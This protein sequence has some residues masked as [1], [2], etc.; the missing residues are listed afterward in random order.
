MKLKYLFSAIIASVLLLVGCE[1]EPIGTFEDIKLSSTNVS[2]PAE[3]GEVSVTLT[4]TIDWAFVTTDFEWLTL[5][6][7]TSGGAGEYV[8]KFS[9]EAVSG[10]RDLTLE[11]KAGSH[12]QY[13]T[14]RQGTKAVENATCADVIAGVDGKVYRVTG[15]CTKIAN[16]LYGNWYLNDGTGEVYVYGTLD[17]DGATKNFSSWKMEAGD[18]VTVEGPRKDYNGTIELVD[19]TVLNIEKSLLKIEEKP[20]AIAKEGGEYLL[21]LS[22]KGSGVQPSV[23]AVDEDG[24][25]VDYREWISV[26]AV[27]TKFGEATKLE[28][29]PADT[30]FVTIRIQPNDG[31][32]RDGRID[33]A[34]GTDEASSTVPFEFTQEGAI[35][36]V[37][38]ADAIASGELCSVLGKVI[39]THSK[40]VLITDGRDVL[41]GYLGAA[42]EVAVNDVVKM[43]G[44]VTKY[45]GGRSMNKPVVAKAEGTVGTYRTP[46]PVVLDAEKFAAYTSA[47]ADFATPYVM[48][49]GVAETDD[50]NNLIVKLV[51][52]ETTYSVKS[53]YGNDSFA[54]WAG[55]EVKAYGYAYNAYADSKQVNLV[56][57]TVLDADA[58]EPTGP[59]ISTI[60][61]VLALGQEDEIPEG[62]TVE[63]VVISNAALSNLTSKKGMYLQDDSGAVQLRF[64][65]DHTFAFGDKLQLDLSGVKV[66]AYNQAVQLSVDNTKA[67]FISAGNTVTPKTVT[68]ADF[69][70]NKYEGQYV[71]LEGV[72]VV[73]ADLA[74]TWGDAKQSSHVSINMED[75]E[76]N[77]FVVFSSKYST[78][79]GTT[80][81][82]GSGTI[83]GISAKS[84]ATI[85]L[86][87][88]QE[89][90]FA[91]LTGA[92]F[93]QEGGE[94]PTEKAARNLAFSSATATA[95]LGE[96]FTA[97]TLSGE[98]AGVVYTSSN[99]AVA[100][101]DAATGVVTLV[102]AGE[103]TITATA[104]ETETLQAGTASYTLTVSEAAVELPAGISA[105][106]ALATAAGAS[107]NVTLNDAVVT[108]VSGSNA[109]VQDT[110]AGILIYNSGHG[111]MA[112][113]KL[114][115]EVSGTVKLFNNLREITDI[116]ISQA[117]KTSGAAIPVTELTL[118]EL[119][120]EGAYDRYENMRISIKNV[121]M[122]AQKEISQ[123]GQK[124]AL[125]FRSNSL[126]GYEMYNL[127]DFVGYPGKYNNDIQLNVYEDATVLGATMTT[128]SGFGNVELTVGDTKANKAVA[129]SGATVSYSSAAENIATVD[130]EGN[131]TGVAEGETTITVSVEA[132]NGYP[133][134]TATCTVN[135]LP[136]GAVVEKAWTLVTDASTLAVGDK[137]VIAAKGSNVAISTE[138]KSN[139]RGQVAITK[140]GN[141]MTFT[142]A[143]Q[144][145]TL[146]AGTKT[147]TFAFNVGPS[148][149]L[150]AASSSSNHLKTGSKNDNAS[151]TIEITSA[152][153]ATI[154][155]QGTNTRN[156][157]R[158]NSQSSLFACYG[159]GQEDVAIYKYQ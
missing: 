85:Q 154:K 149:Y 69:L 18:I 142:T 119:N 131:V 114:S 53:Y 57:V 112:G 155:A 147:G 15:V 73:E 42:P 27:E 91:G 104:A 130:A 28:P 134:A 29:N 75:A 4:T 86:I 13:I 109:Y 148:Q 117:E 87:F 110:E 77:T 143:V 48:I 3:G 105:I 124:Y 59:E 151:W 128:F 135:V 11:I 64:T 8:L 19:V 150:Y 80:V 65:D 90:D 159:S 108:Y 153:V 141:T 158:H 93:G 102:A 82:Q 76:G 26:V 138:Q 79:G 14:I 137:I 56:A 1:Q 139:N 136:A 89:S 129:S 126:K 88:A 133:A 2:I 49:T 120:A 156:W 36:E 94:E 122:T 23:P 83:K 20:E 40:G 118:A 81:A 25:S 31:A 47:D 7:P 33:F 35:E 34:S 145:I 62:T 6:G 38:I 39:F 157:L 60:A 95:T 32:T 22:Y 44:T 9:A 67:V 45:N 66:G 127:I 55:K 111:L 123:N 144:E 54:D 98:A 68:M 46:A 100:T 132:Y 97:P 106:K 113:D 103:T 78:F 101:V 92:R 61:S 63:G 21:K 10:G 140:S 107:F 125:Y 52:G 96:A 24:N 74:K 72:Q 51:D 116:N 5:D 70:A 41:Y 30:A 71:A 99:T 37:T 84:N 121:E 146:E 58:E 50:Y 16:D 43:V 12:S 17:K 115:G 152:G